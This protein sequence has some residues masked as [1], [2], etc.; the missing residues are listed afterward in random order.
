M[1][2]VM[3][4][5]NW[6]WASGWARYNCRCQIRPRRG[7]DGYRAADRLAP[8]FSLALCE[9]GQRKSIITLHSA[10]STN[11]ILI[12]AGIRLW[13][14]SAVHSKK[15]LFPAEPFPLKGQ[16]TAPVFLAVPRKQSSMAR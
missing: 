5:A 7:A 6:V 10:T 16:S 12:G 3:R 2:R 15:C 4:P 14:E 1:L 11:G 13:N 9:G 8:Y